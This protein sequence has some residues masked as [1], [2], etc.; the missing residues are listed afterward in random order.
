MT[1]LKEG[2]MWQHLLRLYTQPAQGFHFHF[3]HTLKCAV[4]T[5]PY[6]K[7]PPWLLNEMVTFPLLEQ[8]HLVFQTLF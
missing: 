6:L 3:Q 1:L 7:P 8:Q 5:S 4:K 2:Q